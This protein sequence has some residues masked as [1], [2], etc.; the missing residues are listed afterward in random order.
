MT[1]EYFLGANSS[2]GFYSLYSEFCSGEG[3]YLHIIKGGPGTGKS[4]F[5]RRIGRAAEKMGLDVEYVLCSGDPDS[6]DGVYVPALRQGWVDGT[7]PHVIEPRHF[8]FDS[9]Y[10]NLGEFCDTPLSRTNINYVNQLYSSY[11][12]CYTGAYDYL[13]AAALVRKNSTLHLLQP[14]H[15]AQ[16][17]SMTEDILQRWAEKKKSEPKFRQRF[18]HAMCCKGE[19]YLKDSL[20]KL[21][22][23]YYVFSS[24]LGSS[25]VAVRIAAELASKYVSE[26]IVCPDPVE[27]ELFEAVLLPELSIG[28]VCDAY[29]IEG[30]ERIDLDELLPAAVYREAKQL[31]DVRRQERALRELAADRLYTAKALHD[32]LETYYKAAMDFAALDE[33][34]EEYIKTAMD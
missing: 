3:D 22:K 33:F 26:L 32:E 27:P 11:K 20:K 34:T 24:A 16:L 4:G 7:A 12:G 28:F 14:A 15:T 29:G 10:V 2:R 18:L 17:R 9:D 23:H 30:N 31:R 6:L 25:S 21:C 5:M 8:G 19:L 1:V 13:R